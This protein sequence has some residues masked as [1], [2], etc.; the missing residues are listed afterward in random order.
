MDTKG[1]QTQGWAV[2]A[3]LGPSFA[4]MMSWLLQWK[5]LHLL[6]ANLSLVAQ[7]TP[8]FIIPW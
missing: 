8:A 6:A 2:H 5:C 1:S 3:S 4:K 7:N